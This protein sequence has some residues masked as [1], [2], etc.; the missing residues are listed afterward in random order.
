MLKQELVRKVQGATGS[1]LKDATR[2]VDAVFAT[3]SD[4]LSAGEEVLVTGFGKFVV[5]KRRARA[6]VNPQNPSQRIQL[7][8][9]TIPAFKAG[10]TLKDRVASKKK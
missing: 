4:A 3:I 9:S 5:R 8:E 7:P 2:A 10:K 6:G 1:T